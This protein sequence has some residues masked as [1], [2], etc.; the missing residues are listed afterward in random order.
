[1]TDA[2][3][4]VDPGAIP[5]LVY[6][7]SRRAETYLY[8]PAADA[9]ARVPDTLL[10]LMGELEL[11]MEIEL[12]PKRRLAREDIATVLRNLRERGYHLQMPPVDTPSVRRVH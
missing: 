12:H 6:K 4:R 11:V 10:E 2:E 1:M 5:T 8:V 7:G 3:P 9:L